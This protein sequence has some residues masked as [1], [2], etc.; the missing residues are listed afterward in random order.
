MSLWADGEVHGLICRAYRFEP[1][2]RPVKAWLL[3]PIDINPVGRHATE[4]MIWSGK[5]MPN[6][7]ECCLTLHLS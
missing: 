7:H 6:E 4:N 3:Q 5:P 1:D 2:E